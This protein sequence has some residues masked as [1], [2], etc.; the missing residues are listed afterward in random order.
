MVELAASA[1]KP[2]IAPEAS[3]RLDGLRLLANGS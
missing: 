3:V 2:Q 1:A